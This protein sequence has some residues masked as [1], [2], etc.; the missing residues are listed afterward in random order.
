MKLLFLIALL[1][2]SFGVYAEIYKCTNADGKVVFSDKKECSNPDKVQVAKKSPGAS[3]RDVK[4]ITSRK[5]ESF[6][7]HA[8]AVKLV[9][10]PNGYENTI[11][12]DFDA[13]YVAYPDHIDIF[14]SKVKI[15]GISADKSRE[16]LLDYIGFHL[17]TTPGYGSA[18]VNIIRSNKYPIEHRLKS[19]ESV[20]YQNL[21]F[22]VST[23]G[24]SELEL[25]KYML[26][27]EVVHGRSVESVSSHDY[28][29]VGPNLLRR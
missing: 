18:R 28:L 20:I 4:E 17:I 12:S 14:V 23:D 1:L 27:G 8:N 11:L 21:L 16:I 25:S 29:Q 15:T 26:A 7:S 10:H 2:H 5:I 22:T 9:L 13:F 6:R 19:G 3:G 24:Y